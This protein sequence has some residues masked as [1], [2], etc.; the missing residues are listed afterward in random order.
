MR[1]NEKG[2]GIVHLPKWQKIVMSF[3]G[4]VTLLMVSFD[5]ALYR[6]FFHNPNQIVTTYKQ[7]RSPK[8]PASMN[9][10]SIVY[11]T[12]IEYDDHFSTQKGDQLFA[13]VR[14]LN[15]DIVLFG[16]DLFA[17]NANLNDEVRARMVS[18]IQS[19][20]APLGKFAVYGEQDLADE[21]H[22]L[23][24]NDVYSKGQVELLNNQSVLL[25]NRSIDGIRLQGVGLEAS[26]ESLQ[27]TANS[28]Q[29]QLLLSHY[30]DNLIPF[31]QSG[32]PLDYALCGNSHGTQINWPFF[33]GY[34]VFDGSRT[35]NRNHLKKLNFPYVISSGIGCI[36]V[37]ARLNSPV[38]IIHF[39][40]STGN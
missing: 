6:A 16:G 23:I 26:M 34:K 37:Q 30:P 1:R 27:A 10:V 19:I 13:Q 18:W 36:N 38:E 33:G 2:G 17:W 14:A 15:P 4:V 24:V 25:A 12:D 3:L 20:P 29:F 11:L 40:L 7:I 21:N 9:Q 22:R 28:A 39:T 5:V 32:I 35:I 31:S 8:I